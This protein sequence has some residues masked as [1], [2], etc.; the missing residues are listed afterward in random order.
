M[1]TGLFTYNITPKI[2]LANLE[3]WIS[4]AGSKNWKEAPELATNLTV[5]KFLYVGLQLK[6]QVSFRRMKS[7]DMVTTKPVYG[8]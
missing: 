7:F 5:L 2:T 6:N 3:S 1:L 8:S 4:R